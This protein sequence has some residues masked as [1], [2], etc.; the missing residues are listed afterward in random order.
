MRLKHVIAIALISL[1]VRVLPLPSMAT[2]GL[3]TRA[4]EPQLLAQS[5]NYNNWNDVHS[6]YVR[7]DFTDANASGAQNIPDLKF[8]LPAGRG[9]TY[10]IAC[11]LA[12]SQATAAADTFGIT[13][14][15]GPTNALMG[16]WLFTNATAIAA[17]PAIVITSSANAAVVTGTPAVTTILGAHLSGYAEIPSP[18][19]DVAVQITI[20]QGTAANVVVVK[21]DSG[22]TFHSMN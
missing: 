13:F 8:S 18:A 3:A 22:C 21:R 12:F 7:A 19:T 6:A 1:T 15:T 20:A 10:Y 2:V 5:T 14:S 9:A 4:M 16:G 11:D 17:G